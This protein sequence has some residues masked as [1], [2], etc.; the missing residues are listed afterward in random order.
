[1]PI[2]FYVRRFPE[3]GKALAANTHLAAFFDRHAAPASFIN[4]V[5]PPPPERRLAA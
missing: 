3:G 2:L 1:M 5:P 4:T